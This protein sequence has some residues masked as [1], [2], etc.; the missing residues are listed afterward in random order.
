M[1][2]EIWFKFTPKTLD[3]RQQLFSDVSSVGVEQIWDVLRICWLWKIFISYPANKYMF[4]LNNGN[5]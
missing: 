4:K 5:I 2:W 3:W 1:M